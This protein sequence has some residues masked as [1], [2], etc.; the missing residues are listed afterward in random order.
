MSII[1][2][3]YFIKPNNTGLYFYYRFIKTSNINSRSLIV[4][5]NEFLIKEKTSRNSRH[6]YRDIIIIDL[7]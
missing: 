7:I 6:L 1:N 4:S 2:Y 5:Y 3:N